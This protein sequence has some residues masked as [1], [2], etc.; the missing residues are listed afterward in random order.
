LHAANKAKNKTVSNATTVNALLL[1]TSAH[2]DV[3]Q[4]RDQTSKV[5][6]KADKDVAKARQESH[7]WAGVDAG[8]KKHS[9]SIG[10]FE[11]GLMMHA[12]KP[13][14][15]FIQCLKALNRAKKGNAHG[16]TKGNTSKTANKVNKTRLNSAKTKLSTSMTGAR[17]N[18]STLA[19]KNS[20]KKAK[21]THLE[22]SMISQTL[23]EWSNQSKLAS[24]NSAKKAKRTHLNVSMITQ[25]LKSRVL[26]LI[27]KMSRKAKVRARAAARAARREKV[28]ARAAAWAARREDKKKRRN[29]FEIARAAAR[30]AKHEKAKKVEIISKL[31]RLKKPTRR[32]PR[33][34]KTADYDYDYD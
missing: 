11:M 23:K 21:R 32:D 29:H 5:A 7:R 19:S 4:A 13:G 24:K 18:E 8:Q 33:Q 14:P 22:L 10:T 15:H 2:K 20:S 31:P 26:V 9:T 25:A 27:S 28:L 3:A 30:A 34:K 16:P 17:S 12:C 6:T 1:A